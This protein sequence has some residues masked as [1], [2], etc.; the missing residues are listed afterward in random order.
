MLGASTTSRRSR[1]EV[2]DDG[3][4][5]VVLLGMGGSSLAPEVLRAVV[6]AAARAGP[7]LHV[8]D[9]TDAATDRAR[10][11]RRSTPPRR[12][13]S[14]PR[15]P[16]GR[17]RRCRSSS[18]SGRRRPTAR[19][20]VAITD[21]GSGLA[22]ARRRA[23]LPAHVPQRPRHRRALQRAVL[24]RP[25]A[26]G[27]AWA[28]TSAALLAGGRRRPSRRARQ[29]DRGTPN[30]GCGWAARW[31]SSRSQGRD[32]LTFVVDAA[33]RVLRPVGRAA[34]RRVDRQA[35]HGHPAR[36]RRAA[37]RR[38]TTTAT[39]ASSSTCATSDAP[40]EEQDAGV[41]ALA[42][43][44]PPGHH[45]STRTARGDLGRDLLL[46]RVRDRGRRAG[47]SGSTRSTSPTC[48]RPRTTRS[49]SWTA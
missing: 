11:R 45:A 39:T 49:A 28:P 15:S 30:A 40:D 47:C 46:R 35:G 7:R 18:T 42:R 3:L 10:S 34:R 2:R 19:H 29:L 21:P 36:R 13:S 32:K 16:A 4:T 38:R 33:A 24:L 5:D 9:S 12:C 25:R 23:R 26:R 27:A 48:R 41:A 43:R 14:S 1:S 20:F 31:A 17:S 6:R 37:R 44:R 22:D 8:L